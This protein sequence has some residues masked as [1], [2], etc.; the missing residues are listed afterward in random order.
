MVGGLLRLGVLKTESRAC[1]DVRGS[2]DDFCCPA[3]S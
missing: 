3:C 1:K 2:G